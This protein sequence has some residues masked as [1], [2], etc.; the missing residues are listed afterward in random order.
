MFVAITLPCI[1]LSGAVY[2][3]GWRQA[4]CIGALIPSVLALLVFVFFGWLFSTED[5]LELLLVDFSAPKLRAMLALWWVPV[6]VMGSLCIA[7]RW[8]GNSS[9]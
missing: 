1:L 6:P 3:R 4:F 5:T 2:A 9:A 8:L 7:I